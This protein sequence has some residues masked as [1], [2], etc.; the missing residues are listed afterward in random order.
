MRCKLRLMYSE[1][2]A[3]IIDEIS[4]VSNTRLYQIYWLCG[5]F[6][7]SLDI[8]F[9]GLTVILLGD[10][11]QLPSVQRK[12]AF[13]PFHNDLMKLFHPWEHFSYFE[14]T[15]VMRQQG[16][17]I[18][19]DLLN[20]V[21]VGAV[22][23][24]D[25][26]LISSR[27]CTIN[28]LSPPVEAIYLFAENSLKDNFNNERLVKLNYPLIEVPNLGKNPSGVC[29]SKLA[30]VANRSQSQ[31]GGL[32]KLF[33]FKKSSRVMLTT[34]VSIDDHLVNGQLGTI[35]DTKEDSS[36]ILNKIYIKFEDENAGLTK[37][38]CIRK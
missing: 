10:L 38:V 35:I 18:F 31:A 32:A 15:E 8:P 7:V 14:L 12:K 34:N 36:G 9:P 6:S 3:V 27:S 1:V 26:A 29:Q 13:A 5:I 23:E 33:R 17:S 25:I 11:Y 21:R 22:S 28:N 2:E 37:M 19:I 4:M 24:I 16:D 30:T 20:N